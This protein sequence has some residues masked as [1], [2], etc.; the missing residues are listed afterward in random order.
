[1]NMLTEDDIVACHKIPKNEN[2]C[3]MFV[4]NSVFVER[5]TFITE[6]V[7]VTVDLRWDLTVRSVLV[8]GESS[9]FFVDPGD[10]YLTSKEC[11]DVYMLRRKTI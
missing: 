6:C 10:C 2:G 7:I 5:H 9:R 4:G 8:Q 3:L 1:M 11:H